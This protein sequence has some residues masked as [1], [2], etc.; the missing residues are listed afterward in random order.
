MESA[1]GFSKVNIRSEP[2]RESHG[3]M[4]LNVTSTSNVHKELVA[5]VGWNAFNELYS[6]GDDK[7]VSRWDINGDAGGKVRTDR[8]P[9]S[10]HHLSSPPSPAVVLVPMT[11]RPRPQNPRCATSKGTSRTCTGSPRVKAA[12]PPSAT[13]CSRA[14]SRTD[15][16]ESSREAV[17]WSGTSRTRTAGRAS[18]SDGTPTEPRSRRAARTER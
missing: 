10:R 7:T 11:S 18:P 15:R 3:A 17:A 12:D 6:C 14:P 16:S 1:A 2:R 8:C 4:R 9:P 5:C 13:T